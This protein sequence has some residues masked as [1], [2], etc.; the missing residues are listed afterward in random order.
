MCAESS[1]AFRSAAERSTVAF[2]RPGGTAGGVPGLG[3]VWGG[4]APRFRHA[5][6]LCR[7]H[8]WTPEVT[9]KTEEDKQGS[10]TLARRYPATQGRQ[11][12]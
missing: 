3:A 2:L 6:L 11:I 7:T 4:L 5:Q 1:V 9:G 10:S 12:T 8:P